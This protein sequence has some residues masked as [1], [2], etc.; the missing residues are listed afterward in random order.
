MSSTEAILSLTIAGDG[1]MNLT[2]RVETSNRRF[3]LKQARPWVEKYDHIA[4]PWERLEFECRFYQRVS[5]I[6]GVGNRMP[7]L[8]A[9]DLS[10]A[11]MVLEDLSPARDWTSIYSGARM[12]EL[13]I[14]PLADYLARLHQATAGSD[15]AEFRNPAMRRLNH[16]H[17][18][19]VPMT[20]WDGRDLDKLEPGLEQAAAQ[21]QRDPDLAQLIRQ[22]G[23]LYLEDGPVLCHGDF[24]PGSWLRVE[25]GVRV[26]DAEFAHAGRPEHDLGVALA[27]LRLGSQSAEIQRRL[28]DQYRRAGGR[29]DDLLLSRFAGIEVIRRLLGVAQMPIPASRDIRVQMLHQGVEAMKTGRWECLM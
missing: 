22:L 4:A 8:I 11:A 24:F 10:A 15:L 19:L 23:A 26:I 7:R 28:V 14:D 6:D 12:D 17:M 25:D 9:F 27:H 5:A 2:L 3:I 29:A 18:F 13:A 1:N 21:L 20:G 16:E